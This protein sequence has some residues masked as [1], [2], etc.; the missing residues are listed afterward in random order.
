MK[1]EYTDYGNRLAIIANCRLL[2]NT[3]EALGNYIGF[4]AKRK[5]YLEDT[6]Y[7]PAQSHLCP[8]HPRV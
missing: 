3:K 5:Q 7:L 4:L 2:F 1:D 8:A 6:L